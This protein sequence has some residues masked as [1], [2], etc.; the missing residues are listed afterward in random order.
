MKLLDLYK[1]IAGSQS[2]FTKQFQENDELYAQARSFWGNLENST[3]LFIGIILFCGIVLAVIYYTTYNNAP[4]RHYR[5]THWLFFLLG[6]FAC[7]F[8][9]TWGVEYIVVKPILTGANMLEVKIALANALYSAGVFLIIS[10]LWCNMFPTN[11]YRLF[12]F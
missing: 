10:V 12:K 4:G 8:L 7:G 2:D 1:W 9:V 5:P 11:A 3:M 6:T